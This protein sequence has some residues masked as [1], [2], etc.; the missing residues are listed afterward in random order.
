MVLYDVF[1]PEPVNAPTGEGETADRLQVR[2]FALTLQ[3]LADAPT[4]MTLMELSDVF[5]VAVSGIRMIVDGLVSRGLVSRHQSE[6]LTISTA[7]QHFLRA[8]SRDVEQS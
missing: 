1:V 3:V 6:M 5:G 8:H 7:G 4:P 2:R